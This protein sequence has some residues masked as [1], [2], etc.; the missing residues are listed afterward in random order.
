MDA[1]FRQLQPLL[2]RGEI[3]MPDVLFTYNVEDN[4]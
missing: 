2:D 4:Q 3:R 1:F